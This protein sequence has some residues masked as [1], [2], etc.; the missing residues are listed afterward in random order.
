MQKQAT[1]VA[2][3]GNKE[4]KLAKLITEC[5]ALVKEAV[6]EEFKEYALEQVHATI[7]GLEEDKGNP[8]HNKN[9]NVLRKMNKLMD[10]PGFADFLLKRGILPF[11][12]QIG[13]F[14][15]RDYP[16]TCRDQSP[17][18]RSA[19][20]QGPYIVL[21]GWPLRGLPFFKPPG[22]IQ[23]CFWETRIYP[24]TLDEIR[25]AAQGF[26]ILHNYH[27]NLTDVDNDFYFRIGLIPANSLDEISKK[28]LEG[29]LR[30]YLSEVGPIVINISADDLYV[31]SYEDPTLPID[32]TTTSHRLCKINWNLTF[33]DQLYDP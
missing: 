1:L 2:L 23:E 4:N 19:S 26:N 11:Q 27:P 3:Y 14:Q 7:I 18:L 33:I 17:F 12:V 30:R 28:K 8:R 6:K 21:M 16:F 9:F 22:S 24:Q 25:L 20:I 29:E 10:L 32:S 5:Q 13:G 15:D 31:V